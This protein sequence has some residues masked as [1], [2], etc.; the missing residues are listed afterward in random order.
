MATPKAQTLKQ[1]RDAAVSRGKKYFFSSP[2]WPSK[3]SWVCNAFPTDFADDF[4]QSSYNVYEVLP[5]AN[6]LPADGRLAT[7]VVW[8][9]PVVT[10]PATPGAPVVTPP[11]APVAPVV[12]VAWKPTDPNIAKVTAACRKE[13]WDEWE[14]VPY[15]MTI[16]AVVAN[17][18]HS[19]YFAE[20]IKNT[21]GKTRTFTYT[22]DPKWKVVSHSSNTFAATLK[23]GES[24]VYI[25]KFVDPN[26]PFDWSLYK[27]VITDA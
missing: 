16:E 24:L 17:G 3:K 14:G 20:E 4:W 25:A 15:R 13:S 5:T 2:R 21:A 10:P 19:L 22:F 9:T 8:P 27:R 6:P 7:P 18:S 11:V 1:V 23:A 12:P 26:T